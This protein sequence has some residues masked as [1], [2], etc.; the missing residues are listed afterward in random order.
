MQ[1]RHVVTLGILFFFVLVVWA[2]VYEG[3]IEKSKKEGG[4]LTVAFLDVGQG[5]AIYIE[6]P[7][8]R[9]MVIDGGPKETLMT[10]LPEVMPFGD[11]SIDVMM[12]TNPD[13]DHYSGFIPLLDQYRVSAVVEPGTHND[14]GMYA[15]LEQKI[16]DE[17]AEHLLARSG[18]RIIL[19][20]EKNVYF[21]ILF[22]DRNVSSWD[23]NDGSIVGRLVYGDSAFLFTGDSTLLTEGIV[24]ANNDI[25]G[26]D[27]LKVG[28][29]G[30][31]TSTGVPLLRETDPEYAVISV[32]AGNRYGHPTKLVLDRLASFG[33]ETLT[34]MNEGTI[35]F[36]TDGQSLTRVAN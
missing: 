14:F 27:V 26:I 29:H 30:S 4:L 8:G 7:N 6:A 12:V 18:Q 33:V 5:D 15:T 9:Q 28:H 31:K 36:E 2:Q 20:Q 21:E 24:L 25:S 3:G 1:K 34:T 10:A 16:R 32:G 17:G 35:I 13:L 23:S 11:K 19:D 22:P